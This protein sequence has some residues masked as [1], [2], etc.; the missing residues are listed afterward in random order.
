MRNIKPLTAEQIKANIQP[1]ASIGYPI[2]FI[3]EDG[4][5]LSEEAVRE[6][7]D[8]I[9]E[10]AE[11]TEDCPDLRQWRLVSCEINYEDED[12]ICSHTNKKIPSAY[13]D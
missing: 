12:L 7:L 3:A 8:R 13:A 6:Q 2:F 5:I 1:S 9:I 10:A 4:G 11:D